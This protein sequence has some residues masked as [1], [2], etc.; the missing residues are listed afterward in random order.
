MNKRTSHL[1]RP[2]VAAFEIYR[3]H[4]SYLFAQESLAPWFLILLPWT[5]LHSRHPE[6]SGSSLAAGVESAEGL[7]CSRCCSLVID[8]H[9][10]G[11]DRRALALARAAR[12]QPHASKSM[13]L[14]P[15][16]YGTTSLNSSWFCI[17][18]FG[19]R[20]FP[21]RS[22]SISLASRTAW[23]K[24]RSVHFVGLEALVVMFLGYSSVRLH[25]LCKTCPSPCR[26]SLSVF[27]NFGLAAM[28]GTPRE[29]NGFRAIRLLY[30]LPFLA[31]WIAL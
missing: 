13:I 22:C 21:A 12:R 17:I 8:T 7:L 23:L 24:P 14:R 3:Y 5:R 11:F 15:H 31:A 2:L 9:R 19:C 28:P 4:A 29:G 30:R 25:D 26:P 27:R 1:S 6:R 16:A 18:M 10:L 20:H